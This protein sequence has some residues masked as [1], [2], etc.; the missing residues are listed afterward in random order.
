MSPEQYAEDVC[1]RCNI[2]STALQI[3][4]AK[5]IRAYEAEVRADERQRMEDQLRVKP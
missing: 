1:A 5:A 2:Y 3:E 4:I